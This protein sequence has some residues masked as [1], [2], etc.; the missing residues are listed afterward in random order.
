MRMA[1]VTCQ[2]VY[3]W[4][5]LSFIRRINQE[6]KSCDVK[7]KTYVETSVCRVLSAVVLSLARVL[8]F[9]YVRICCFE[10]HKHQIEER[11][12]FAGKSTAWFTF[13]NICKDPGI[14]CTMTS[15]F[16]RHALDHGQCIYTSVAQFK[17][18]RANSQM[19]AWFV[20]ATTGSSQW[21]T[22]AHSIGKNTDL[23]FFGHITDF[24]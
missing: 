1:A 14:H 15:S 19:G 5:V 9:F 8:P 24:A 20:S 23:S 11:A 2:S 22:V 10:K 4:S 21:P 13:C 12:C 18:C 16:I 3:G 7:M 6:L 17:F